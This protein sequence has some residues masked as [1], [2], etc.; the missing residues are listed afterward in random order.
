VAVGKLMKV[1]DGVTIRDTGRFLNND[2]GD[3]PW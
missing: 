3:Q 1:I 2:G